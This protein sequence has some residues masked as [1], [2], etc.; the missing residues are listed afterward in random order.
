M[1]TDSQSNKLFLADCLPEKQPKLFQ[2]FEKV[3]N[4]CNISFEF[5]PN[6][7]DIW[8]VDFMPVQISNGKFVQFTYSPDYLKLKKY[9]KT[10]S[11][12]DSICKSIGITPKKSTIV[13]DGGNVIR[14]LTK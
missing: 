5:L 14:Q 4:D 7:K 2:R 12:V 6:T 9:R 11:N 13:V 3:L 8:A 10:I 1:I